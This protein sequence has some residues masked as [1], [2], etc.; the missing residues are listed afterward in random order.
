MRWRV[1]NWDSGIMLTCHL[2]GCI[3]AV[4]DPPRVLRLLCHYVI[5]AQVQKV[6]LRDKLCPFQFSFPL[7]FRRDKQVSVPFSLFLSVSFPSIPF[8]SIN[9]SLKLCLQGVICLLPTLRPLDS[10]PL[11]SFARRIITGKSMI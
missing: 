7:F 5:C 10:H 4:P 2:V 9:S 3:Q 6:P 1:E 8:I 11:M